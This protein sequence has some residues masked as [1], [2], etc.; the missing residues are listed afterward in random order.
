MKAAR[1][2][3]PARERE[4]KKGDALR[5]YRVTRGISRCSNWLTENSS[6]FF[7]QIRDRFSHR[8]SLHPRL[9]FW[10]SFVEG[11]DV[12]STFENRS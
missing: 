8:S 7:F 2:R 4:R 9:I 3:E 5:L 1:Q 12:P 10:D 6:E 11:R